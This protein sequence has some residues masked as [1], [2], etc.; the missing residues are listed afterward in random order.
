MIRLALAAFVCA[1]PLGA[2]CELTKLLSS[3]LA[4]GDR[5]GNGVG[6]DGDVAIVGAPFDDTGDNNSGS[7]YVFRRVA[8]EWVQEEKLVPGDPDSNDHFGEAV[9]IRGTIAVCG[10]EDD[11]DVVN[12]AGSVYVFGYDGAD[13]VFEQKIPNPDPMI[14]EDFG[15]A[16]ATNGTK[17]AV[18]CKQD[19]AVL[20]DSGAVYVYRKDAGTWVLEKK[21]KASDAQEDAQFGDAVAYDGD[22]IVVGSWQKSDGGSFTGAA[23]VFRD[24]G[25]TWPE[26]EKLTASDAAEFDWFGKSVAIDGDLVAVGAYRA[27]DGPADGPG[28][29]YAFR[30]SGSVWTEEE[31]LVPSDWVGDD[32]NGWSCAVS[33]SRI[34]VGSRRND[35]QG[36]SSGAVY[37]FDHDGATWSET[38]KIAAPDGLAGDELAWSLHASGT[39]VIAGAYFAD[40]AGASSGAAYVWEQADEG[41]LTALPV[42]ASVGA[43]GTVEFFLTGGK[44]HEADV[45]LVLGSLTGTSP[46]IPFGS[47]VL[48][49]NFDEYTLIT[50][51]NPTVITDGVGFLGTAGQGQATLTVPAGT[52]PGL[53][54][55]TVHHAFLLAD[56]AT[57]FVVQTSNAAPTALVL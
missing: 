35:E 9:A 29:V 10:M 52:N 30:R 46:G 40:P 33:G 24:T 34:F 36:G 45:Y 54:G 13:W 25:G 5:L 26:E 51:T 14:S 6:I 48:P 2:Q 21:L 23:Y 3:D 43:G 8:G 55:L 49:L 47:H 17:I 42:S 1:A 39:S 50:L 38:A 20:S 18:G 44:A 4:A 22:T 37:L 32:N 53:A 41:C 56:P 15:W 57:L 19:E 12:G 7:A 31:K 11:D 16:V 28:A 27:D